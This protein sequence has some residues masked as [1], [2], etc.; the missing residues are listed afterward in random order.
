MSPLDPIVAPATP[1]APGKPLRKLAG[2]SSPAPGARL[3]RSHTARSFDLI[4]R[5]TAARLIL[6]AAAL[7]FVI[8]LV[9]GVLLANARRERR[10]PARIRRS[11][12]IA[13]IDAGPTIARVAP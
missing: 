4:A 13:N 6:T 9:A 5:S 11:P 8:L 10:H 12:I 7:S 1:T 3:I 2:I